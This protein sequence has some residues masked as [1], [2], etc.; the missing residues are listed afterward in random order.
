MFSLESITTLVQE[1]LNKTFSPNLAL[2][3]EFVIVGVLAIALFAGLGL[4]LVIM[5]R[6]VAAWIQIRLGPNR[7][8]PKGMFQSLADTVKL[9]MKEGLTPDGADKF[10]F[11]LAPFIV[12]MV[13][14]LVL[15]PIG[16]AKGFHIWDINIGVLYVSAIS[17]V[18]VIG[19]L[20]AGWAS[21]NKY[22][23]LGAMR[24]G[25]QMVSYELSVGLS[26]LSI[27][28]LT[29][30]LGLNDIVLSQQNGWWIF[31][32]HIPAVISFVI[33]L[34]AVTAETNRAPFDLAEAESELT[35]GFHTEYSGM[36]F[37]LF[38]L[39]EYINIFIVCAIGATLFLGGWMPF[40]I[41]N[42]DAF[43]H[44]MD[45]IPSFLWF[46]GKTFFLIFLI[47]WFRWTFPRLRVDQLLNLEW[48]YL[49][50]I[51]MFNLILMTLV[52]IKG[53]HF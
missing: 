14:M 1:W 45:Y 30:S 33:F 20:M 15:A 52:A 50:P 11:N 16:F 24:S 18:S 19:I 5:E 39:A 2:F 28:V 44:I 53:W 43:N 29:G 48:K 49:L 32:G 36:K 9:I 27:I 25:A 38:F 47:M 51:S 21:N 23:L 12:M 40:H 37:A 22:S 4:V 8:G 7:V 17:S 3:F 13:A 41:G 31:K 26:V 42:W 35:A 6:K 46:F 34:I 10:L